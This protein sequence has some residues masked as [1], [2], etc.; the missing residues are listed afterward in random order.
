MM[1]ESEFKLEETTKLFSSEAE[2]Q[3]VRNH[4]EEIIRGTAFRGSRRSA[5]FLQYIVEHAVSHRNEPLRERDIGIELFGRRPNYDTNDDAIVRVTASDVRKR[6]LQHYSSL[7]KIPDFRIDLRPGGY[8]PEIHLLHPIS[9]DRPAQPLP[10]TPKEQGPSPSAKAIVS[11]NGSKVSAILPAIKEASSAE[12][13]PK[14]TPAARSFS[15][16]LL[17]CLGVIALIASFVCGLLIR[18]QHPSTPSKFLWSPLL[19]GLRPLQIVTSDPNI[20]EIA[21]LTKHPVS[22]SDYANRRYGCEVLATDLR[23]V[24]EKILRGDKAAGVDVMA[25]AQIAAFVQS[26]GAE[27]EIHTARTLQMSDLRSDG[28]YLLL[29]SPRSDPWAALFSDQMDFH[30]S[31][32]PES[33]QDV[34]IDTDPQD[35]ELSVYKPTAKGLGT[36]QSYAI[37]GFV[38]NLNRGGGVLLLEGADAEGTLAA[39]DLVANESSLYQ[40]RRRCNLPDSGNKH[41]SALIRVGTMAE[42]PTRAEVIACHIAK[43]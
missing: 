37:I 11:E 23:F 42:A 36:G 31:F 13:P 14:P 3:A 32:D 35:G 18:R 8:I 39:A 29:G 43:T 40:L 15:Q 28:N 20:A 6:L 22:V 12:L 19:S 41:F 26:S 21:G 24:C 4:L 10:S 33:N 2:L 25:V 38:Q 9:C 17:V 16:T 30:I 7:G 27:F 34:I 5:Q 1:Q